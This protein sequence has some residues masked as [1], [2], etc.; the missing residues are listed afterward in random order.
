[1]NKEIKQQADDLVAKLTSE[2]LEL[3]LWHKLSILNALTL[4]YLDDQNSYV[5]HNQN[6]KGDSHG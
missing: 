3:D 6:N 1:M 2:G 4:A 5:R